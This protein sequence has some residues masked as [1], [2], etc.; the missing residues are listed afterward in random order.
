MS[1]NKI[2]INVENEFAIIPDPGT[3]SAPGSVWGAGAAEKTY[4]VNQFDPATATS[5]LSFTP[6]RVAKHCF[7]HY[8]PL[9]DYEVFGYLSNWGSTT[10]VMAKSLEIPTSIIVLVVV[11]QISCDC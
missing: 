2:S 11:V 1:D 9:D 8:E 4:Q 7:N 5:E 10:I 3:Q 6:G